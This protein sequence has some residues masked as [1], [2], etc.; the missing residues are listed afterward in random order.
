M[1]HWAFLYLKYNWALHA[2][3]NS[4]KRVFQNFVS[5]WFYT[6]W[7]QAIYSFKNIP[8][9]RLIIEIQPFPYYLGQFLR[10]PEKGAGAYCSSR[11]LVPVGF[12]AFGNHYV[13]SNDSIGSTGVANGNH[14]IAF[15][16]SGVL[17]HE[18]KW[19]PLR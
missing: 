11:D 18:N 5:H 16:R 1:I 15:G 3:F 12:N 9:Y 19:C 2:L 7:I 6:Q 13:G 8:K 14:I 4:Y 10:N 17:F